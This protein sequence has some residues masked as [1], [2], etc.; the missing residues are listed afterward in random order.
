MGAKQKD[1]FGLYNTQKSWNSWKTKPFWNTVVHI[2]VVRTTW[3]RILLTQVI[4]MCLQCDPLGEE[5]TDH[6][7]VASPPWWREVSFCTFFCLRLRALLMPCYRN[8][9]W[10]SRSTHFGQLVLL[11][12]SCIILV[13][14]LLMHLTIL[15]FVCVVFCSVACWNWNVVLVIELISSIYL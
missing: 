14:S 15:H 13:L 8:L 3:T 12:R 11:S 10:C 7:P 5:S 9:V 1:P 6:A 4:R 2:K